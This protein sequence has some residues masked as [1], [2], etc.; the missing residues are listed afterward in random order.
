MRKLNRSRDEHSK[1]KDSQDRHHGA[2]DNRRL[3]YAYRR[4][5]M[6]DLEI[7]TEIC[8]ATIAVFEFDRVFGAAGWTEHDA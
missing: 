4:S 7:R 1:P 6:F 3:D 5:R 8:A 2:D